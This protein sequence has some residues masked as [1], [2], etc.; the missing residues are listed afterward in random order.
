MILYRTY[1]VQGEYELEER[2]DEKPNYV[3]DELLDCDERRELNF[4]IET[5]LD[6]N[7]R[8][9]YQVRREWV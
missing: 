4:Y 2:C 5:R 3:E 7:T 9:I 6:R 1:I 8:E